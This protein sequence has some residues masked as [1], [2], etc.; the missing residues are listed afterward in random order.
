[1]RRGWASRSKICPCSDVREKARR[2]DGLRRELGAA[3]L[4]HF[5]PLP[6][7]TRRNPSSDWLVVNYYD[8]ARI[9]LPGFAPNAIR[10]LSDEFGLPVLTEPGFDPADSAHQESFFT[11]PAW[12]ALRLWVIHHPRPARSLAI[13]DTYLRG[14][15]ERAIF[16]AQALSP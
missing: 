16:E 6:L 4:R 10:I 3:G 14:W 8:E 1:M 5:Q 7:S 11:S 12:E 13:C 9:F 15:Y 2:L